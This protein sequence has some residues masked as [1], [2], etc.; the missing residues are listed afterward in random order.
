MD[1]LDFFGRGYV[2]DHCV[3]ALK[4]YYKRKAFEVYVTDALM[5]IAGNT[6]RTHGGSTM[7]CRYAEMIETGNEKED[8]R[9]AD[10]I[11]SNIK[12]KLSNAKDKISD[13][14]EEGQ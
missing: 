14:E 7:R 2:I 9:T 4:S 8:T 13:A 11:I 6:A 3:S 12:N 10:D 5:V 1:L